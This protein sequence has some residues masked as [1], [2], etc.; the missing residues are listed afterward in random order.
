MLFFF[1]VAPLSRL[2]AAGRAMGVGR[3]C[4]K[5]KQAHNLVFFILAFNLRARI[6]MV[7]EGPEE[8]AS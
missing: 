7:A 8:V 2:A 4:Y 6:R 3:D 1:G 5:R